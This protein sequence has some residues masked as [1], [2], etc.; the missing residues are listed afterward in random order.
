VK[1][2]RAYHTKH[3]LLGMSHLSL[4]LLINMILISQW[5]IRE[6]R[7]GLEQQAERENV[8]Y[9]DGCNDM[10]SRTANPSARAAY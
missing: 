3:A 5:G 9:D 4:Y 2:A 6:C 8:G 7:R 10:S 1:K